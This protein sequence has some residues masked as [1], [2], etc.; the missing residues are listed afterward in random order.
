MEPAVLAACCAAVLAWLLLPSTTAAR[1][2]GR[3]LALGST[4]TPSRAERLTQALKGRYESARERNR[5]RQRWREAV[6]ELC[7]GMASELAAGRSPEEAFRITAELLDPSISTELLGEPPA[8]HQLARTSPGANSGPRSPTRPAPSL[9]AS[10]ALDDAGPPIERLEKLA[11]NHGAEGLRMLAASWRI[12]AERG[13]TLATV[14]DGLATALRDEETQRQEVTT[15]LAG[16]RATA[17]LLAALPLLG[18]G[19]AVALGSNPLSFLFGTA[20]GLGC[21]C[22]GLALN[23]TGFWWTHRLA[24]AAE[25]LR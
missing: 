15:Q 20:L 16:P 8:S 6:I 9:S 22:T 19:M 2:L 14:L 5:R 12:G 10:A 1:R 21:L 3:L 13:G 24:R 11:V 4:P 17:R 25:E 7:D 23:L 18:L